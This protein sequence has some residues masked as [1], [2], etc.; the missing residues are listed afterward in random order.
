MSNSE[1]NA[2]PKGSRTITR[3]DIDKLERLIGLL[4]GVH[5]EFSALS[6][7]SPTDGVNKF[8]LKLVNEVVREAN[9]FLGD[10]YR[11]SVGF[12]EFNVDD[13]PSNSDVSFVIALY[14]QAVE[15]FRADHLIQEHG[16]WYFNTTKADRVRSGAP[17]KVQHK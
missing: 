12:E 9:G 13:V 2:R 5:S 4:E 7:K 14:L 15:R 11:P 3:E 1:E 6:K 16:L 8:K 17:A 10:T